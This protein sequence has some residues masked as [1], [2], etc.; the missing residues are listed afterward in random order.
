MAS[1][2]PGFDDRVAACRVKAGA[3][4]HSRFAS[5]LMERRWPREPAA[6]ASS[7]RTPARERLRERWCAGR[8]PRARKGEDAG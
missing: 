3:E 2:G 8:S 1:L 6:A 5:E 7:P 4:R